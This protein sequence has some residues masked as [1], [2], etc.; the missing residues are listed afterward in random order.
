MLKSMNMNSVEKKVSKIAKKAA[1]IEHVESESNLREIKRLTS[2][3][4]ECERK[5]RRIK[6]SEYELRKA[7][8]FKKT[9]RIKNILSRR[10]D[11]MT[12]QRIARVLEV[13]KYGKNEF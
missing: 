8:L 7:R 1:R 6:G 10:T 3:T 5:A 4:E 9:N 11:K 12:E 2:F 13:I